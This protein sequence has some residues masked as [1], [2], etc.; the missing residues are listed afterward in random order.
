MWHCTLSH[1]LIKT[2]QVF[3]LWHHLQRD[4]LNMFRTY[5]YFTNHF[6]QL[7]EINANMQLQYVYFT[8]ICNFCS[9]RGYSS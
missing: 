4:D 5:W 8:D 1:P 6:L 2:V 3:C 7:A 9:S